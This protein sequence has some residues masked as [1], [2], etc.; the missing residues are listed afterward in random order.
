MWLHNKSLRLPILLMADRLLLANHKRVI[1]GFPHSWQHQTLLLKAATSVRRQPHA[2]LV[3]D[4]LALIYRHFFQ[5]SDWEKFPD[6]RGW[7]RQACLLFRGKSQSELR[8]RPTVRSSLALGFC[9]SFVQATKPL[10]KG[11]TTPFRQ[12]LP[13]ESVLLTAVRSRENAKAEPASSAL[14]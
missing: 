6:S 12:G 1:A 11:Q 9:L 4:R 8:P 5:V 10:D 7:R 2:D 3:R 14:R 13:G